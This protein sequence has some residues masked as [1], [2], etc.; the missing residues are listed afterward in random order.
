[1]T[2]HP[3]DPLELVVPLAGADWWKVDASGDVPA[4]KVTDGPSGA[5]GERFAGGPAS[6]SFPCPAALG[7][8]WDVDLVERVGRALA[9]E[10]RAKGAHVVALVA[11]HLEAA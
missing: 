10:T 6:A 3:T 11:P 2:A 4:L 9:V 5:R 8:S 1:M 7:A